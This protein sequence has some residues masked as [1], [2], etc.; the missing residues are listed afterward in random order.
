[1]W[2][3][4]LMGAG[5]DAL[6]NLEKYTMGALTDYSPEWGTVIYR[7][8]FEGGGYGYTYQVPY[9]SEVP[10]KWSP[11]GKHPYMDYDGVVVGYCHSHPNKSFFSPDDTRFVDGLKK[12]AFMVNPNGGY[13]Y[14]A[15]DLTVP[16]ESRYGK[17][18]GKFRN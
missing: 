12:V 9:I 18:W 7:Y 4:S 2:F 1:M 10:T 8:P 15:R 13:W 6:L 3:K 5:Y 17:F 16:K 14:D 11:H